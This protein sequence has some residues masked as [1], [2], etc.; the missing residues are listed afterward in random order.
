M[1]ATE[2]GKVPAGKLK[3]GFADRPPPKPHIK[4]DI[5]NLI[6]LHIEE[7]TVSDTDSM[8]GLGS[9]KALISCFVE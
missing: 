3:T 7:K 1:Q 5:Y 8:S 6:C 2:Q 9:K 4:F